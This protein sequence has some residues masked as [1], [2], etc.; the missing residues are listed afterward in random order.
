VITKALIWIGR[1]A[2]LAMIAFA[3]ILALEVSNPLLLMDRDPKAIVGI[4][5]GIF[6]GLG[7]LTLIGTQILAE[8]SRKSN[9]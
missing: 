2:S 6:A 7:V 3:V 9:G 5:A 4:L 8:V 1:I